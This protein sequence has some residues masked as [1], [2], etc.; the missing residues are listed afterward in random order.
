MNGVKLDDVIV[1]AI[2]EFVSQK[3][4]EHEKQYPN[5]LL[6]D[7]VLTLLD[8]ECM[9]IYYPLENDKN[10]GFHINEIPT[11]NGKRCHFVFI[12]TA[13]TIE[14]QVFTAAHELGHVWEVEKYVR[15][16]CPSYEDNDEINE[17]IM[18]RFAA[19]LLMPKTY[20]IE[21]FEEESQGKTNPDGSIRVSDMLRVIVSLMNHF[22][23]PWK[24][25]V[26]RCNELNILSE[27]S[28]KILLGEDVI[29]KEL[30]ESTI[31]GIFNEMGYNH[32][33]EP[34]N[35]K[36]IEG[37]PELLERAEKEEAVSQSKINELRT[38]FGLE[39]TSIDQEVDNH[40]IT[41]VEG[42]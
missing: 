9:V 27:K 33:K 7:D 34:T 6:R 20:F 16:N 3:W 29:S 2:E 12:N 42:R 8:Q 18:N 10:N 41:T 13:Q 37:L 39:K 23:V 15:E 40:T 25:A 1:S 17:S 28:T 11:K 36:W 22:F 26:I 19:N 38:A 21:K 14:K 35:K 4:Q 31:D 24:S 32:F 5:V 30:I